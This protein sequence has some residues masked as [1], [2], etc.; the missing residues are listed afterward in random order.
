MQLKEMCTSILTDKLRKSINDLKFKD[1]SNFYECKDAFEDFNKEN[2]KLI[3]SDFVSNFLNNFKIESI[4]SN[5]Q[6]DNISNKIYNLI[7]DVLEKE[8]IYKELVHDLY[9]EN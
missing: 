5:T 9:N 7:L 4:I 6:K 1:I 3:M 8:G 2:L